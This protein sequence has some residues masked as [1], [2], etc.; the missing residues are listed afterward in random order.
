MTLAI[1]EDR[2]AYRTII[3]EHYPG[4]HRL[5]ERPSGPCHETNFTVLSGPQRAASSRMRAGTPTAVAPAG[6]SRIT[7]ALAPIRA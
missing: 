5:S 3:A 1:H 2:A 7:T 6:T 4:I